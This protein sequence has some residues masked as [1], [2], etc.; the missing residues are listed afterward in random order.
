M[1][2]E[3]QAN[4]FRS[5]LRKLSESKQTVVVLTPLTQPVTGKITDIADDYLSLSIVNI[6]DEGDTKFSTL[7]IPLNLVGGIEVTDSIYNQ[8]ED[9]E[10]KDNNDSLSPRRCDLDSDTRGIAEGCN[11]DQAGQRTHD[12]GIRRSNGTCARSANE[13]GDAI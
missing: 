5:L 3:Q 11:R 7:F 2:C 9:N 6:S 12:I 8:G 4:G 1:S 10:V 13:G